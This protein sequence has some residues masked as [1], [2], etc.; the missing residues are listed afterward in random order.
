MALIRPQKKPG[1]FF[2]KIIELFY[3]IFVIDTAG[4]ME[5]STGC[6]ADRAANNSDQ[7]I[8]DR[9]QNAAGL[10]LQGSD[11]KMTDATKEDRMETQ[12]NQAL[13]KDRINYRYI[14]GLQP[15]YITYKEIW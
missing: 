6:Q 9:C 5:Y 14:T 15:C 10:E 11:I 12:G 1:V 3:L 7:M 4:A 8:T 13:L 2:V